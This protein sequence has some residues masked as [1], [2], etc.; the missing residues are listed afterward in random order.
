MTSGLAEPSRVLPMGEKN[1]ACEGLPMATPIPLTK[2]S[3]LDP[4]SNDFTPEETDGADGLLTGVGNRKVSSSVVM[5]IGDPVAVNSLQ[6]RF[7]DVVSPA[8]FGRDTLLLPEEV[9]PVMTD[10][11][12]VFEWAATRDGLSRA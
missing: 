11:K 7:V 4:I 5:M 10:V 1:E 9:V 3:S 2:R 8:V 6:F 12:D